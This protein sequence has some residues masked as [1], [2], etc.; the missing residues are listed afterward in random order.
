MKKLSLFLGMALAASLSLTNCTE[1]IEGPIAPATPAGI[2]FEI[3]A[4]ISTKTTNNE[5]ATQWA[6]GDAINLFHAVAGTTDYVS[7]NDFTLDATRVGVFT[8][9]LTGGELN[10]SNYDWYAFYPYSEYNKTPAGV[11]KDT[12]G[13]THIGDKSQTQE[14]NDSKAHLCGT[15][16]PLYG[17]AKGLASDVKP[18]IAMNNLASVVAVKVKNTTTEPLVVKSVSFTSTEDIV[19]TYYIDFTGENVVYT[20]SGPDY[21]SATASLTVNNGDAIAPNSEATFYIPI[22]PHS[23]KTG[24]TLK[25]SVNGYEKSLTLPKDVTFTAGKIKTL[26]FKY[27]KEAETLERFVAIDIVESLKSGAKVLLVAKSGEKYYNLPVNPNI[28]NGKIS[29]EDIS[30]SGNSVDY[31]PSNAWSMVKDGDYW[32]ICYGSSRLYHAK[33]GANGTDLNFGNSSQFPWQ[34]TA[35]ASKTFKFASVNNNVVK[36]RG[37]LYSTS[38][39]KFGGYS[40]SNDDG[41]VSIMI[42]VRESDLSG[43]APQ[44]QLLMPEVKC[45]AQTENSLTYSW[46]VVENATKYQVSTNNVDWKD[47]LEVEYTM[48][49]L[50]A[51]TAYILYVK[52]I[53]DGT[54][55]LDSDVASAKG[56]TKSTS[57]VVT[58][59][60]VFGDDWNTLF[61]TNY[62][63]TFNPKANA[64]SLNGSVNGVSIKVTNGKSTNGLIRKGDFRVYNGYTITFTA[65]EGSTI[66]SIVSTKGGKAFTS[67]VNADSGNL[68]I[69]EDT[70]SWTGDKQTVKLTISATV[71][72]ATITITL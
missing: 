26:A 63:G 54:N 58:E 3:S 34:I 11:S 33:G 47:C 72:F 46:P 30:I 56:I 48:T 45:T 29:G 43:S 59:P 4:D 27:D 39:G 67:G 31:M 2:P 57:G 6:E 12:F 20:G 14:G 25:I 40:L 23:V 50:S 41:Y 71:S 69:S 35:V 36:T 64:L 61:G 42:F 32:Q 38:V 22:K 15:A 16:L 17:V 53:G 55:Y 51:E 44:P 7:D 65:P 18:S 62:S 52:A 19:G 13:Y 24:S 70:I 21:V 5:L 68:S 49:G 8:G 1:K 60:I 10:A 9:N 37:L 66:K 28:N